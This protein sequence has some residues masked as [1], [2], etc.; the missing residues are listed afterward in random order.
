VGIRH[1]LVVFCGHQYPAD[2]AGAGGRV[3]EDWV[4]DVGLGG[5]FSVGGFAFLF[6]LK[7]LD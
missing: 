4:S 2:A 5:D 7:V 3:E 6:G 1:V